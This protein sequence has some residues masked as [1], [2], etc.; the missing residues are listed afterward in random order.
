[1]SSVASPL[2]AALDAA[3]LD[4]FV[5]NLDSA[6]DISIRNRNTGAIYKYIGIATPVID[7]PVPAAV[8]GRTVGT[9]SSQPCIYP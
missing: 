2:A 1:M 3:A 9:A 6:G 4:L 8:S 5:V 7:F